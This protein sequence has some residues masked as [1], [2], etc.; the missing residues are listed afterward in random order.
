MGAVIMAGAVGVP[1]MAACD[2]PDLG[3]GFRP[4]YAGLAMD[5]YCTPTVGEGGLGAFIRTIIV[6]IINDLAGVAGIVCV[7]MIIYSGFLYTT[8]AGDPAK[9]M[10]AKKTLTAAI[11]GLVIALLSMAIIYFIGDALKIDR[12]D[13]GI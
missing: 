3:F 13:L 9:A 7:I 1:A 5:E 11:V 4:W 6:N 8:S 12:G 10:K 2:E